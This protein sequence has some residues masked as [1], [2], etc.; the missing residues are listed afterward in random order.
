MIEVRPD[1]E[2]EQRISLT[3]EAGKAARI[4]LDQITT[5][6]EDPPLGVEEVVPIYSQKK[7]IELL[8]QGTALGIVP[9][10]DSIQ[11][12]EEMAQEEGRIVDYRFRTQ[13][14]VA[15]YARLMHPECKEI[16]DEVAVLARSVLDFIY[17]GITEHSHPVRRWFSET[18]KL[19][20]AIVY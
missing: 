13:N 12:D 17:G 1:K 18:V 11:W 19:R 7:Q 16:E 2:V 8:R 14:V 15:Q 10:K 6:T 9:D 20:A 5:I 4:Y 3:I